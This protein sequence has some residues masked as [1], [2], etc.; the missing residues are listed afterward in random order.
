MDNELKDIVDRLHDY[1]NGWQI[2]SAARRNDGGW[3]LVIQP[4]EKK[5]DAE[6]E[7]TNDQTDNA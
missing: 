1:T 3:S 5:I 7:A 2:I 4:I 6:P